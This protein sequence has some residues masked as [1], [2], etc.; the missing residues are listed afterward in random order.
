MWNSLDSYLEAENIDLGA[1]DNNSSFFTALDSFVSKAIEKSNDEI[2]SNN[3]YED[4]KV[5]S[6]FWTS[7]VMDEWNSYLVEADVLTSSQIATID[8]KI[9]NLGENSKPFSTTAIFIFWIVILVF[10]GLIIAII[11][12]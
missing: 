3:S 5:L 11:I 6:N 2:I 12:K 10:I 8:S 7:K 1:F 9:D 4:F